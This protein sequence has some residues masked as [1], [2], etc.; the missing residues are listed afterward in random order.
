MRKQTSGRRLRRKSQTPNGW[1]GGT[2]WT[3]RRHA[4]CHSRDPS[5]TSSGRFWR[6]SGWK[7]SDGL[8]AGPPRRNTKC[9]KATSR[10]FFCLFVLAFDLYRSW[11]RTFY[12]VSCPQ[13]ARWRHVA[14]PFTL[15]PGLSQEDKVCTKEI[16]KESN[17][18]NAAIPYSS[19]ADAMKGG[20]GRNSGSSSPV[21]SSPAAPSSS[22]SASRSSSHSRRSRSFYS[23]AW[24]PASPSFRGGTSLPTSI[25]ERR[26]STACPHLPSESRSRLFHRLFHLPVFFY[27]SAHKPQAGW[28]G[29]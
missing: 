14:S 8:E 6:K 20:L 13:S 3:R 10:I 17:K 27:T 7:R 11:R 16:T 4:P 1:N 22:A 19:S 9:R 2:T 18:G 21:S 12:P 15:R 24:L 25:A 28:H 29:R 23:D 5:Q 26:S